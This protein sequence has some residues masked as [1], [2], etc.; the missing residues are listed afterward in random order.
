MEAA[1]IHG[2]IE[3]AFNAGEVENLV[4]LYEEDA[5]MAT[6]DGTFK[7]GRSAIREQWS[8]FVTLGGTIQMT[9]QRSSG[10]SRSH[11]LFQRPPAG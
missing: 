7:H 8:G 3:D 9:T 2:L 5:A 10:W 1:D 11:A 4:A 6:P